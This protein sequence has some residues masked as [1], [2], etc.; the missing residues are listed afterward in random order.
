[1]SSARK[2]W[3]STCPAAEPQGAVLLV[4]SV[5]QRVG[6]Y[7]ER[8]GLLVRDIENSYLQLE[9][10]DESAL[11]DLIDHSMTCMDILMLQAHD[12][13]GRPSYNQRVLGF[14]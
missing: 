8:L 1:M 2:T 4:Q 7:L 6:R 13:Q 10:I 3:F 14:C 9:S 12:A 11:D 5:S